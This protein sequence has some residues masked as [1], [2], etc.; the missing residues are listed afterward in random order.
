MKYKPIFLLLICL[1]AGNSQAEEFITYEVGICRF[2]LHDY[3]MTKPVERAIVFGISRLADTYR[4]TFG[5]WLPDNFKVKVTIICGKEKFKEYQKKQIG[6]II[7]E[8]GYFSGRHWETVVLQPKDSKKTK[9]AK[10][11]IGVVFHEANHMMMA[12][13]VPWCPDWLN[14]GLSEYFEGLNVMGENRRV[15]LQ[16]ARSYWFKRWARK[17][18]PIELK[19]YLSLSHDQWMS[20]RGRDINAAYT[21]GYS[22]IYFMMSRESTEK[23][24]KELLWEFRRYGPEADSIKIINENYPGGLEKLERNWKKWIPRARP[25]RPLR[26]LRKQKEKSKEQ[27]ATADQNSKK[28]E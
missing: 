2:N 17:G 18:F 26:A 16:E 9:D 13:C 5:F 23:V 25:Y 20:L 11:M 19:E 21:I 14:E 12:W 3:E 24:L 15:Y 4:D 8:T 6:K 7:S 22:L 28:K 10:T 27:T 1:I